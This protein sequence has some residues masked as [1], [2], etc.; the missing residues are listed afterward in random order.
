[1]MKRTRS[2]YPFLAASHDLDQLEAI[3]GIEHATDKE[4]EVLN[5][6]RDPGARA[7]FLLTVRCLAYLGYLPDLEAVPAEVLEYVADQAGGELPVTYFRDRPARRTDILV[8][9]RAVLDY[10]RWSSEKQN[11]LREDLL[12]LALDYPREAELVG[13]A[14]E[15]LREWRTELPAEQTLVDMA[16]S[17]LYQV[18]TRTY[19][20]VV[21]TNDAQIKA[22]VEA[23]MGNAEGE[24]SLFDLIKQPAK[25][26]GLK[27][28]RREAAKLTI[29]G[30][31]GVADDVLSGLGRRK[32]VFLAEQARRYTLDDL[33]NLSDQRR[34]LIL[35][36]FII[37]SRQLARDGLLDQMDKLLRRMDRECTQQ[38]QKAVL[39]REKTT[40]FSRATATRILSIIANTPPGEIETRLFEYMP[41]TEYKRIWDSVASEEADFAEKTYRAGLVQQFERSYKRMVPLIL[42][43]VPFQASPGGKEIAD[44]LSVLKSHL[45][46]RSSQVT[47]ASRPKF[48]PAGWEEH[49]LPADVE[50]GPKNVTLARRP[51]ELLTLTALQGALKSGTVWVQGSDRY[52]NLSAALVGWEQEQRVTLYE[53]HGFPAT[54]REFTAKLLTIMDQALRDLDEA[55]RRGRGVSIS[56]NLWNLPKIVQ[57]PVS[58]HAQMLEEKILKLMGYPKITEVLADSDATL[59]LSEGFVHYADKETRA[60]KNKRRD[61]LATLFCDAAN[62]GP[63]K[64]SLS[65]P[66]LSIGAIMHT[67]KWYNY[68]ENLRQGV[69]LCNNFVNRSPLARFWGDGKTVSFDGMQLTTYDNNARAELHLRYLKGV[70]GLFLQHV[71]NKLT[72]LY[73]QFTRCSSPEAAHLLVGLLNHGTDM[74]ITT[75]DTD[76]IGDHTLALGLGCLL[77]FNI[78][79]RIKRIKYAKLIRPHREASYPKLDEMFTRTVNTRIIEEN[80]DEV[81]RLVCSLAEKTVSPELVIKRFN[82]Y[83]RKSGLHQAL[84]E[85][86]RIVHTTYVARYLEEEEL[87][88]EIHRNLCHGESWNAMTRQIFTF[89]RAIMREN[90]VDE[91][92]RLALS[93]LLVQNMIVVWNV[94]HLSRAVVELKRQ[95]YQFDPAD[96]KHVTPLLTGHI[97]MIPDFII[98]FD[99]A[100]NMTAMVEQ[101]L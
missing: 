76:S 86:G 14:V 58:K 36:A 46:S 95:G 56:Q 23:L 1:M 52:L 6:F 67:Q 9:A 69:I 83:S 68:P 51:L 90:D 87:R 30:R 43:H 42:K 55:V 71:T 11:H 4:Q 45:T 5:E 82:S 20:E 53:R 49:L 93:L 2:G 85:I 15:R 41:Q 25:R 27:S 12:E 72:G 70:G 81:V 31:L 38:E 54:A 84:L 34:A 57:E 80:Y 37:R 39:T 91:Q 66:E 8:A 24:E 22:A 77:G 19:Q 64:M 17:A 35:L 75:A 88:R 61:I 3:F 92:E 18:E 44:T 40:R 33:R 60:S 89:N 59:G 98:E 26:P 7:A 47:L 101:K 10:Q 28:M 29:L 32:V 13:A 50:Q 74:E 16:E 100:E 96:L 99:R 21:Q 65:T 62:I 79:P 73:G 94:S 97:R 78:R 48:L 63:T